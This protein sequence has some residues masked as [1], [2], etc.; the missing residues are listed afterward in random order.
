MDLINSQ[1][2]HDPELPNG[3]ESHGLIFSQTNRLMEMLA[4]R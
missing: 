3:G 2:F 4:T 1:Y